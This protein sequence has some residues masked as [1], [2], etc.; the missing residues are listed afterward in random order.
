MKR[1]LQESEVKMKQKK[2]VSMLLVAALCATSLFAIDLSV[3]GG[4]DFTHATKKVGIDTGWFKVSPKAAGNFFG[5]K[6]FFDAQ[7]VLGTIGFSFGSGEVTPLVSGINMSYFN[8][9]FFGKYPYYSW[10]CKDLSPVWI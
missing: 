4:I 5:I 3:G 8:M 9:A 10:Y 7:Y 6:C 1:T 2:I